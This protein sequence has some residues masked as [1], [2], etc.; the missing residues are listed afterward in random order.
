[1][2]KILFNSIW[3]WVKHWIHHLQNQEYK[4]TGTVIA[5]IFVSAW[6]TFRRGKF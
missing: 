6:N 3:R 1:M 4:P 5:S 2:F